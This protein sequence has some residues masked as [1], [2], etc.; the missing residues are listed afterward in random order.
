MGKIILYK[1][2]KK[3]I[4]KIK[5]NGTRIILV[6]GCFDIIHSGHLEFFRKAKELGGQLVVI[7]ESD[8]NVRR[9]KGAGRPIHTQDDRAR[10]L[11]F[12]PQ[13]D[14]VVPIPELNSDLEY[15]HL[16][17]T[18]EPDIIAVT[19]DDPILEK[20]H[21]QAKEVHGTV[22][23]VVNRLKEHSTSKIIDELI[24]K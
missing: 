19:S 20:K 14:Y 16:V 2:L 6:G 11:S 22:V 21:E 3:E 1:D 8:E 7:L 17:K 18:I 23:E 13:V 5:K 24:G 4:E 15:F 12:L 10:V 9:Y